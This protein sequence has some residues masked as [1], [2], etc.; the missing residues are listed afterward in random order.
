MKPPRD[1]N[2]L[3]WIRS[4]PCT[5]C[6]RRPVEA[7][8]TT[9]NGMASKGSDY[10]AIPLCA[11][12]H[13]LGAWAWHQ[14]GRRRF[15]NATGLDL[16]ALTTRLNREYLET[17]T[18]RGEVPEGLVIRGPLPARAMLTAEP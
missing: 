18:D 11:W 5:L 13:R 16:T 17:H 2:Y 12:C 3:N 1:P 9:V 10:E 7:H 8:H 15:L 6:L 4:L 14:A